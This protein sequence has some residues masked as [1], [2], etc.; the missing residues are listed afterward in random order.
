VVI[1]STGLFPNPE[2]TIRGYTLVRTIAAT[3][4][5]WQKTMQQGLA[6]LVEQIK[7]KLVKA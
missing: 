5:E 6:D 2:E 4:G 3:D 7:K 1:R